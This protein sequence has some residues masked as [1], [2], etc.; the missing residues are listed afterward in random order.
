MKLA[1][2]V[3][4]YNCAKY[5][6]ECFE[7]LMI[8][9]GEDYEFIIVNDGS[10]DTSE[11]ICLKYVKA[12][13]RFKYFKKENAGVSEA[14]N[15]G[16]IKAESKYV[17]FLDADDCF[18]ASAHKIIENAISD[19]NPEYDFTAFSYAAIGKRR[20]INEFLNISED[21]VTD[22]REAEKLM[23]ASSQLNTSWGKIFKL[24]II[25]KYN[26]RFKQGMNIGEDFIFNVQYFRHCRT[27]R[28]SK[29]TLVYYRVHEG[30]IMRSSSFAQRSKSLAVMYSYSTGLDDVNRND[31]LKKMMHSYYF[32]TVTNLLY[33]FGKGGI[34][35]VCHN[36]R[37]FLGT[38]YVKNIIANADRQYMGKIKRLEHRLIS[39]GFTLLTVFYFKVKR[40][41]GSVCARYKN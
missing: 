6:E 23:Y 2:I 8:F 11:E 27:F 7:S 40:L 25:R 22:K 30:S 28:L 1:V 29:E 9:P 18:C 21:N 17:M 34:I 41:A 19:A 26:I 16:L 37:K 15:Y 3:P 38:R 39:S 4:V 10:T 36:Y 13:K 32:R 20:Y 5:I 33:E 31:I 12:D 24:D 35:K 14:R